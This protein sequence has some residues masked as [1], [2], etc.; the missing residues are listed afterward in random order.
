MNYQTVFTSSLWEKSGEKSCHVTVSIITFRFF[1]VNK[2]NYKDN[3]TYQKQEKC[4]FWYKKELERLFDYSNSLYAIYMFPSISTT[5]TDMNIIAG[6]DQGQG[7]WQSWIENTTRSTNE[8]KP[9]G[10]R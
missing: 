10:Q 6:A 2:R 8:K 1:S 7:A 5:T 4:N 9:H 3:D